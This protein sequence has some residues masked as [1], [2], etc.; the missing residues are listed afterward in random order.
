MRLNGELPYNSTVICSEEREG[1][2]YLYI[3]RWYAVQ[4]IYDFN[5]EVA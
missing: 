4:D 5:W 2:T 1:K 3:R